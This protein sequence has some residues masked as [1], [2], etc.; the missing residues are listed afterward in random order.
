LRNPRELAPT[1]RQIAAE[2]RH[3]YLLGY[4]PTAGGRTGW[5]A[6]EVRVKRPGVRVRAREGYVPAR[7]SG[8]GPGG[9]RV[10]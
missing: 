6:L 10:R 9:Q 2:L 4:A 3:Q 5:R 8:G 7:V 1:L